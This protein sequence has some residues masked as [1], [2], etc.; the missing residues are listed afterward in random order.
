[1]KAI[2]EIM[3]NFPSYCAKQD[4]LQITADR[5]SQSKVSFLP[6]VDENENVIGTVNFEDVQSRINTDKFFD[7]K[8]CVG[9]VMRSESNIITAYDDEATALRM[10][11]N[12]HTSHL[13][14]VDEK[15]HLKGVV[16]FI[17]LARRIVLLKQ[18][19]GRDA[20]RLKV[21]GLGLSM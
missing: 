7:D 19:L 15:N 13:T 6:V 2:K 18:E 10:M 11:R 5:M 20:D 21:R 17:T 12:S 3:Q 4:K 16:S 9:D 14:V 1:M 8:L